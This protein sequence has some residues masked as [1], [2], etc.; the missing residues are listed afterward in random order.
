AAA[1]TGLDALRALPGLLPDG[2]AALLAAPRGP[3]ASSVHRTASG[4]RFDLRLGL[5]PGAD[6]ELARRGDDLLVA[7]PG[8]RR[9]VRLPSVL[10]RCEATAA[11]V[12][13]GV[14]QVRFVPDRALWP[15][16]RTRE[17]VTT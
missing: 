14:L 16:T 12:R 5:L 10:R 17:Q 15:A 8:A 2:A 1:P 3:A 13:D 6:V 7:V 11:R 4:Y 9:G